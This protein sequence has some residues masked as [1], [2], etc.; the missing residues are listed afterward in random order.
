MTISKEI[1]DREYN[2]FDDVNN[3]PTV[4][5]NLVEDLRFDSY[6]VIR[7]SCGRIDSINYY[8]NGV[9]LYTK[10]FEYDEN[11]GLIGMN[12]MVGD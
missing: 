8:L 1:K 7:G 12:R 6:T 9:Y 5:V 2:K 3:R 4:R 11:G 10:V